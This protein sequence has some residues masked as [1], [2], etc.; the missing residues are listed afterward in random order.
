MDV[1]RRI[2]CY[3][4]LA[5]LT[6]GCAGTA[7]PT[8]IIIYVTPP[9]SESP[10][11]GAANPTPGPANPTPRP[12]TSPLPFQILASPPP[13][14]NL[15]VGTPTPTVAP[16]PTPVPTPTPTPPVTEHD[17]VAACAGTPIPHAA[18]YAGTVHPL[19]IVGVGSSYAQPGVTYGHGGYDIN[20]KW[21]DDL[22][23]G[24]IQLVVCVGDPRSA[25]VGSCGTYT[26][27]SD[28]K[29]GQIIRNR[30]TQKVRVVV[31]TTGKLLQYKLIAGSTPTCAA[32]LT[33]PASGPPPWNYYGGYPTVDAINK[34]A[35]SVSRQ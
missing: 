20:I 6:S 25:K 2:V 12:T 21:M 3:L 15:P 5:A 10:T 31:A 28:G 34:Y 29:V 23:P 9:P 17:L 8:P 22:W 24:P 7:P 4:A 13:D 16:T 18:R 35:V 32:S 30:Y 26:R 14:K 11:P 27:K 33:L 1:M 19:A